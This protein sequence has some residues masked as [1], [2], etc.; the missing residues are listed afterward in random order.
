MLPT[1]PPLEIHLLF[2]IASTN[3]A[4]NVIGRVWL[5]Q[6]RE[7]RTLS[8]MLDR[9]LAHNRKME[10][11][12]GEL[13]T[14]I[15]RLRAQ[16]EILQRVMGHH[17]TTPST[18]PAPTPCRARLIAL[19]PHRAAWP[20][21]WSP[22]RI[23]A[24]L[25]SVQQCGIHEVVSFAHKRATRQQIRRDLRLRG[26]ATAL[27]IASHSMT[28]GHIQLSGKDR[29]SR[30]WLTR[31]IERHQIELVILCACETDDL[32]AACF[33]GGAKS[34]IS[35]ASDLTIENLFSIVEGLVEV[36]AMG[37]SIADCV[38]YALAGSGDSAADV[39]RWSGDGAWRWPESGS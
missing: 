29:L 35:T 19:F 2:L 6:V 27:L 3:L 32:T 5:H 10:S 25:E 30:R 1:I 39:L 22:D 26:G 34:V 8:T 33:S 13:R 16:I 21:A 18:T 15:H 4:L 24:L 20:P 36:L 37:D 38:D 31:L 23:D 17:P 12:M 28:N 14:E 7:E 11:E 9:E